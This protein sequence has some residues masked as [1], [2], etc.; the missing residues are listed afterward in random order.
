MYKKYISIINYTS[1]LGPFFLV[2]P[3]NISCMCIC[4]T[5][6]LKIPHL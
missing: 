5:P 2:I 3:E 4:V 6:F 1:L